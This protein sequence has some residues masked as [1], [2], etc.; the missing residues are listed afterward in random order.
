MFSKSEHRLLHSFKLSIFYIIE[1]STLDFAV[2]LGE[3]N[4]VWTGSRVDITKLRLPNAVTA[5]NVAPCDRSQDPRLP[6]SRYLGHDQIGG[7]MKTR[8]P[9]RVITVLT[10][11]LM[12]ARARAIKCIF[13]RS[14]TA[15]ATRHTSAGLHR[16]CPP[17]K[18]I[19]IAPSNPVA[20]NCLCNIL[21]GVVKICGRT[22][23]STD[24]DGV[25]PN[26]VFT[27]Q[28]HFRCSYLPLICFSTNQN[29]QLIHSLLIRTEWTTGNGIL[30]SSSHWPIYNKLYPG[31]DNVHHLNQ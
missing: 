28:L 16:F 22:L 23:W 29:I 30:M 31:F 11:D 18:I 9:R 20:E 15:P 21:N 24:L 2:T 27:L 12:T 13:V 26:F 8:T 5:P 7:V 17:V 14:D 10:S 4:I 3:L 19:Y 6:R 25:I 1:L